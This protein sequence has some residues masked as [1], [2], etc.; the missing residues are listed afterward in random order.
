MAVSVGGGKSVLLWVV[1]DVSGMGMARGI[2][3][4]LCS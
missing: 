3:L 4:R 2:A 1:A